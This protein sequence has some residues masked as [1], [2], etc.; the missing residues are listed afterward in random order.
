MKYFILILLMISFASASCV[1][2]N[3]ASLSELDEI[4]WVGPAT[5]QKIIDARPFGDIDDLESVPGIGEIKIADIKKEGVGCV[6]GEEDAEEVY[7]EATVTIENEAPLVLELD[8]KVTISLDLGNKQEADVVYMSKNHKALSLAP[9]GLSLILI[10]FIVI[11]AW[12]K[13]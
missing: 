6:D 7:R 9:Y 3:S 8:E 13:F 12:D 1:D 2:I 5:A 4:V 10:I 11:L